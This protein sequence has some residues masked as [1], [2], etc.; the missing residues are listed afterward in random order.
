PGGIVVVDGAM[1]R[2]RLATGEGSLG[3]GQR[4]RVS[5][6]VEGILQVEPE[7]PSAVRPSRRRGRRTTPVAEPA[8][9]E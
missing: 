4:I 9:Q 5:S 6:V 2:A 8:S 3:T 1:W 7:D